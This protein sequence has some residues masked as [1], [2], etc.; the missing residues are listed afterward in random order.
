MQPSAHEL[1]T[2]RGACYAWTTRWSPLTAQGNRLSPGTY[3]LLT[4][5][6]SE[7]LG[8]DAVYESPFEIAEQEDEE[9]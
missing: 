7:E 6:T 4:W 3:Q 1:P 5:V 9:Y 8:T 2:E